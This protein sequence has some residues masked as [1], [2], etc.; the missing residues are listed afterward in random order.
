MLITGTLFEKP[1]FTGFFGVIN[2]RATGH[3]SP[4]PTNATPENHI[5]VESQLM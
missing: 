3:V 5:D 4:E 1:G 2:N